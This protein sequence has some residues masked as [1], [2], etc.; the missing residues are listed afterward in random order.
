MSERNEGLR[1]DVNL[2]LSK[3]NY[4]VAQTCCKSRISAPLLWLCCKSCNI[5]F[6]KHWSQV[7]YLKEN[8]KRVGCFTQM[9]QT[10]KGIPSL[11]FNFPVSG[12]FSISNVASVEAEEEL[13]VMIMF[14]Y[15]AINFTATFIRCLTYFQDRVFNKVGFLH[16]CNGL[17]FCV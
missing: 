4:I 13:T 2:I 6:P 8:F 15:L 1:T 10:C 12:L 3:S 11:G 9:F 16:T 17:E 14:L 7:T 5:S